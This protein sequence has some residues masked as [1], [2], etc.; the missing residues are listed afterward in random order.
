MVTAGSRF[1]SFAALAAL[2][3][4]IPADAQTGRISGVVLGAGGLAASGPMV[5]A[6][7]QS[8]GATSRA[9]TAADG[10][11]TVSNPAPRAYPVSTSL[12]GQRPASHKHI[13]VSAGS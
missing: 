12:L 8:T 10:S 7:N 9:P 5:R 4:G 6:T 1:L 3:Y 2:L 13:R 11:Y